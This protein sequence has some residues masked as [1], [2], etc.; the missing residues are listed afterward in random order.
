MYVT[1]SMMLHENNYVPRAKSLSD[2]DSIP[3]FLTVFIYSSPN[4]VSL[5]QWMSS[6]VLILQ[7]YLLIY[8]LFPQM[9]LHHVFFCVWWGGERDQNTLNIFP[10]AHSQ[11]PIKRGMWDHMNWPYG[12]LHNCSR[13][14]CKDWCGL[15]QELLCDNWEFHDHYIPLDCS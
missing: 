9:A 14:D 7:R 11:A 8:D 12:R 13:G 5:I 4:M 1:H 6:A 2:I 3:K 10:H 15:P